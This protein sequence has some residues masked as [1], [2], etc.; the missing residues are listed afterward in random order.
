M[1]LPI[2][3]LLVANDVLRNNNL[4][5]KQEL[6]Y[7]LGSIAPDAIH[8]RVDSTRED[9]HKTHMGINEL[10]TT[11]FDFQSFIKRYAFGSNL[12]FMLGYL[13]HLKTDLLWREQFIKPIKQANITNYKEIY[14]SDSDQID[15]LLFL[16][17]GNAP[18]W[19]SVAL[20]QAYEVEDLLSKEEVY[21][22][23]ERILHFFDEKRVYEMPISYITEDKVQSFI[24]SCSNTCIS[25]LTEL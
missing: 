10:L 8:M 18:V 22:W 20:G 1:A 6:D 7:L 3:H 4:H 2:V 11:E 17:K 14:Y 15:E 9:K 25:L 24:K 13:V 16:K 19:K 12:D 23:R 5:I 21:A